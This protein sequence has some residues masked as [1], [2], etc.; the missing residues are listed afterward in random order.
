MI[1][2]SV[3]MEM[4]RLQTIT[5][6]NVLV[7]KPHTF[8]DS[9][10]LIYFCNTRWL[11]LHKN[12]VFSDYNLKT[13]DILCFNETHFNT[14]TFNYTSLKTD[15]RTHLMI[16]VN[17]QNGTMF[18]YDNFTTLSSHKTFTSFKIEYIV[19]TFRVKTN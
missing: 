6:R 18:V 19:T 1:H 17:G 8:C 12:H 4:H 9:H 13:I 3:A 16:S 10:V 7:P 15:I 11:F 5:W 2:W 14:L